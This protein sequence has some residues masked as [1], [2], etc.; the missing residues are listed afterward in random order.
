MKYLELPDLN[1]IL[2][3]YEL[4]LQKNVLVEKLSPKNSPEKSLQDASLKINR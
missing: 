1:S 3:S 4:V 2:E